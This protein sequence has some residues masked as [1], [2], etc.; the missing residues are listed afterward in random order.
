L[1][2][3]SALRAVLAPDVAPPPALVDPSSCGVSFSACPVRAAFQ[4]VEA[5]FT[6]LRRGAARLDVQSGELAG[7]Q[8][9]AELWV[10]VVDLRAAWIRRAS[11]QSRAVTWLARHLK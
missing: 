4:A 8:P 2:D 9:I 1:F 11:T 3:G 10:V 5:T 6:T 7:D